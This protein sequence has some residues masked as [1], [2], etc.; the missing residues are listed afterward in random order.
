MKHYL[1]TRKGRAAIVVL[2]LVAVAAIAIPSAALGK[3]TR[4]AGTCNGLS[5][6]NFSPRSGFVG[7]TVVTI[8]GT[9]LAGD[10]YLNVFF[11]SKNGMTWVHHS[12]MDLTH[13]GQGWLTAPVPDDAITGPISIRDGS[14]CE[15]GSSQNFK[16]MNKVEKGA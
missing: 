4:T 10:N 5:I 15:F 1:D 13:L 8:Y 7:K 14:G 2:L 6:S 16:V 3:S 11:K 9:H 12:D